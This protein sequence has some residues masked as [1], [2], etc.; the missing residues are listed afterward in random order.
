[1]ATLSSILTRLFSSS[2]S[3]S[4]GKFKDSFLGELHSEILLH[5]KQEAASASGKGP[6]LMEGM[7][8]HDSEVLEPEPIRKGGLIL[9][10]QVCYFSSDFTIRS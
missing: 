2:A 6:Q 8:V 10:D 9:S 1:M 5:V 3:K 4:F 7:T